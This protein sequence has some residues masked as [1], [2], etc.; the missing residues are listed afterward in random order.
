MTMAHRFRVHPTRVQAR[1]DLSILSR[2]FLSCRILDFAGMIG[3]EGRLLE[4]GGKVGLK[5]SVTAP[6]RATAISSS[7]AAFIA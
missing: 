7:G 3:P 6:C 2:R 1:S 4:P 5:R